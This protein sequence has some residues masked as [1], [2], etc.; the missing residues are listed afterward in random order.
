MGAADVRLTSVGE[1]D[2]SIQ[3]LDPTAWDM[4]LLPDV[5]LLQDYNIREQSVPGF[6][7]FSTQFVAILYKTTISAQR[8]NYDDDRTIGIEVMLRGRP[9]LL[10]ST[11]VQ[12]TSGAG[13]DTLESIIS[14]L[15]TEQTDFLVGMD[16][17]G[18]SSMWGPE[19]IQT[20]ALGRRLENLITSKDLLVVN[21]MDSPPTFVDN[22]GRDHWIDVT[23]QSTLLVHHWHVSDH[24]EGLSDHSS[25]SGSS[26]NKFKNSS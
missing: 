23:L 9:L 5:L 11:Y 14:D 8:K 15:Q 1:S 26:S 13:L 19:H 3:G 20:N 6:E 16:A 18:H 7:I 22:F 25:K 10:L 21:D 12:P 2:E 24:A 4:D 17:N